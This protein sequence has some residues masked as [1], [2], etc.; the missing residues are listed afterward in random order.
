MFL[1]LLKLIFHFRKCRGSKT[2]KILVYLSAVKRILESQEDAVHVVCLH[3]ELV[4]KRWNTKS[5]C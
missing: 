5:V 4:E 1:V 2:D 3:Q